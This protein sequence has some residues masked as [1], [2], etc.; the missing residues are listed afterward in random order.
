MRTLKLILLIFALP[1]AAYNQKLSK[2]RSKAVFTYLLR[3]GVPSRKLKWKAYGETIPLWEDD[4]QEWAAQEN[5]RVD[6][7]IWMK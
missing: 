6:I 1:L 3:R 2:R 5:R 4:E 7:V